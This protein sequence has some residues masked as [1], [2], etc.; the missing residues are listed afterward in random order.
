MRLRIGFHSAIKVM[1]NAN[2]RN[3]TIGSSCSLI[4][5]W[6]QRVHMVTPALKP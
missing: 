6:T 5:T 2:Y 1:R 3:Y 4:G